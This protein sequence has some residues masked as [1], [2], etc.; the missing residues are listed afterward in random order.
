[1]KRKKYLT[2]SRQFLYFM[3]TSILAKKTENTYRKQ[4]N[5]GGL[6]N[7]TKRNGSYLVMSIFVCYN[8][9]GIHQVL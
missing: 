8:F 6:G 3:L 7:I 4:K 2:L 1:M 9:Y 5:G